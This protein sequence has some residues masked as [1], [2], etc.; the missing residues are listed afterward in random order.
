LIRRAIKGGEVPPTI[1][2]EILLY[3]YSK[4]FAINPYVAKDTPIRVMTD[5]LLVHGEIEKVKSEEIENAT[6]K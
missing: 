4:T 2:L 5:M 3:S 1:A 6:K